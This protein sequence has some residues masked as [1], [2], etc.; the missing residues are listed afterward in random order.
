MTGD[1]RE[2]SILT[3]ASG[4]VDER[5]NPVVVKDV[6]QLLRGS[7]FRRAMPAITLGSLTVALV[8]LAASSRF[9]WDTSGQQIFNSSVPFLFLATFLLLPLVAFASLGAERDESTYDLLLLSGLNGRRLVLGKWLATMVVAVLFVFAFAPFL[10]ASLLLPGVDASGVLWA[11]VLSLL[12]AGTLTMIAIAFATLP[13]ARVGRALLVMI[14]LIGAVILLSMAI[15]STIVISTASLHRSW[16]EFGMAVAWISLMALVAWHHAL[17]LATVRLAHPEEERSAP[18]RRA[19]IAAPLLA[20]VPLWLIG[21]YRLATHGSFRW[22]DEN[23]GGMT[24]CGLA[25]ASFVGVFLTTEP[26][27]LP[28]RAAHDLAAA[29]PR[30]I[31]RVGAILLRSGGGRGLLFLIAIFALYLG[32]CAVLQWR[33]ARGKFEGFHGALHFAEWMLAY[34]GITSVLASACVKTAKG[35]IRAR[36]AIFGGI[37]LLSL[38]PYLVAMLGNVRPKDAG[39]FLSLP[40]VVFEGFDGPLESGFQELGLALAAGFGL[41]V[42]VPRMLE[43]IS[44]VRLAARK[45]REAARPLEAA[46]AGPVDGA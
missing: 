30:R 25:L 37:P 20:F 27:R 42:N 39:N 19:V 1:A 26:G 21:E 12:G 3:R 14:F 10:T 40:Y 32:L 11:L 8:A 13:T 28:K 22:D 7:F 24:I 5:L 33:L 16:F 6:R 23:I 41:L 38:M 9:S 17:A 15:A 18:L 43:G 4:F 44:E 31:P 29:G 46:T 34:L 2:P 35:R 36:I 45:P